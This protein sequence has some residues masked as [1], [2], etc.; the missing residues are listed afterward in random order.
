VKLLEKE[1]FLKKQFGKPFND[2][3]K[4]YGEMREMVFVV[5]KNGYKFSGPLIFETETSLVR[6]DFKEGR[7]EISKDTISVRGGN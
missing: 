3:V 2:L 4:S 5:L 7:I 6:N 1:I